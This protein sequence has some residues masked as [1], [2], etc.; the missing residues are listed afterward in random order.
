M[1]P[2]RRRSFLLNQRYQWF[3]A[4]YPGITDG[5]SLASLYAALLQTGSAMP[6]PLPEARWAL[7]PPFH[8]YLTEQ[9]RSGGLF[10]VA[11]SL[12]LPSPG[13]TR[14]LALWSPDFPPN[15]SISRSPVSP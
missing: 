12:K 2:F 6:L 11:L 15:L 1:Q 14:R 9:A 8:P 13:V 4:A 10:S 3:L 7:T 5:Q